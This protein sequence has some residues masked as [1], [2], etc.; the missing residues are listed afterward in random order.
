MVNRLARG[1][2]LAIDEQ[3]I[4]CVLIA[5]VA[6]KDYRRDFEPK[7]MSRFGDRSE[8]GPTQEIDSVLVNFVGSFSY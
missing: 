5:I 8:L 3:I 6:G 4:P 1:F 2:E 7:P